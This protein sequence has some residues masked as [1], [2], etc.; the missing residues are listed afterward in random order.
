VNQRP[1]V[2]SKMHIGPSKA[3]VRSV[4]IETHGGTP[5]ARMPRMT[6]SSSLV[7]T[8]GLALCACMATTTE[9]QLLRPV[10]EQAVVL[11]AWL[12]SP[13][14]L[15][16]ALENGR[17]HG[18][19]AWA[20]AC[21]RV[22]EVRERTRQ[23][24]RQR[25]AYEAVALGGFTGAF[26]GMSGA[27][28][29]ANR[30][31]FSDEVTCEESE[32]DE[33][34]SCSSPRGEAT[35]WGVTLSTYALAATTAAV[36]TAISR[37]STELGPVEVGPA[38]QTRV[39]EDA[40]PCGAGTLVGLRVAVYRAGERVASAVV[41]ADG[42]LTFAVPSDPSGPLTLVA[43]PDSPRHGIIGPGDWLGEL[44]VGPP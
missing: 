9:T 31:M 43:D 18:H 21:R 2:S 32:D 36:A 33:P 5:F 30:D 17:A 42:N 27:A 44:V 26:A 25:P 29:L 13:V 16:L 41:D 8:L 7:C 4:S 14:T 22:V 6:R 39:L 15:E 40:A 35:A 11:P 12:A 3:H 24:T 10:V 38:E 28:L 34:P 23:L 19:V 37:S 1:G 20:A